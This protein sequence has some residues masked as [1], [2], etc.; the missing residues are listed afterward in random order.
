MVPEVVQSTLRT[1][2]RSEKLVALRRVSVQRSITEALSV[3]GVE[4]LAL[5]GLAFRAAAFGN[6]QSRGTAAD[7]DLLVFPESVRHPLRKSSFT[8]LGSHPVPTEIGH[9]RSAAWGATHCGCTTSAVTNPLNTDRLIC[10]GDR[11][12]ETPPGTPSMPAKQIADGC[13]CLDSTLGRLD[14]L[15]PLAWRV[16]RVR[17]SPGGA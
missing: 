8:L 10:I 4:A 2:V 5:K 14:P 9:H 17:A 6:C 15:S 11:C 3:S 13:S 7:L 12:R 16:H 1:M